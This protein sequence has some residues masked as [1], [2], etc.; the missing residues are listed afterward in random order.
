MLF[1]TILLLLEHP[2]LLNDIEQ[3][4]RCIRLLNSLE[5]FYRSSNNLI[6]IPHLMFFLILGT[7]YITI[8]KLQG[9]FHSLYIQM[10]CIEMF[11]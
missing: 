9:E 5:I 8:I 10:K 2:L 6:G 1:L 4:L 3:S 11:Q 7:T